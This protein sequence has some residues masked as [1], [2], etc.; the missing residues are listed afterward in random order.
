MRS[1]APS[2]AQPQALPLI[3]T[4]MSA[5]LAAPSVLGAES[6]VVP[7]VGCPA[8]GQMGP[9]D[10]PRGHP[11]RIP[12]A[13]RVANE[14]TYYKAKQGAGVFAPRGWKCRGWYGS[15][16]AFLVVTPA[17]IPRPYLPV[18]TIDSPAVRVSFADGETSGRF[19]VAVTAARLFPQSARGFIDRVKAEHVIPDSSFD[20]KPFP[21]D[22]LHYL[23]STDVEYLTPA[24]RDGL[25]TEDMLE[26]SSLPVRGLLLLVPGHGVPSL[27]HIQV[28]L[29]SELKALER[30]ILRLNLGSFKETRR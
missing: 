18:P 7:F 25:G 17:A 27:A 3:V 11:R 1:K 24:D 9:L 8:D 16:G 30:V 12:V 23:T 6:A 26:K 2:L 14:L 5:S 15:S 22:R 19:D 21:A 4:F 20:V 10:P 13:V 29:P 28:R